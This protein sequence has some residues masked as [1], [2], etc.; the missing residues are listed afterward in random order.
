VNKQ[1]PC[2]RHENTAATL[3]GVTLTA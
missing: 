1:T 3:Q 2:I